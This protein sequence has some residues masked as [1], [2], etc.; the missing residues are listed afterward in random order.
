M[1]FY[2]IKNAVFWPFRVLYARLRPVAYAKIIGVTVNGEVRIYGS[3]YKMFSTEPYLVTLHDNVFISV[4]AQFICHDGGVLPF[5][6]EFPTLDLAAPITIKSNCFIGAGAL[7]MRGVTIGENCIVAAHAVVTK[8]VPN[9]CVVGGN[10]AKIIK[11][12]EEY[13]SG[14]HKKSLGIGNLA[15]D[16][17]AEAYKRILRGANDG[18]H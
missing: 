13:L 16:Q 9:G 5:R 12:T 18:T 3:S 7:I 11:S 8:D 2:R 10:P 14:A 6:R 15:G 17:K 1:T 4:G